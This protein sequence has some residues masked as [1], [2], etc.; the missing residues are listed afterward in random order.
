[1]EAEDAPANAS[2]AAPVPV[3]GDRVLVV[4]QP[5]LDH[6]LEGRKTLEL[7]GRG[8]KP[9]HAWLGMQGR[10]FGRVKIGSS[11][12][13]T[14]EDFRNRE[15]QHL[16]PAGTDPPYA[17]L[18]GLPL[19]DIQR[20]PAPLAYWRPTGAMGWNIYRTKAEDFPLRSR[21]PRG[22]AATA[23][24]NVVRMQEDESTDRQP[25]RRKAGDK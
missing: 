8:C 14:L 15:G 6:I 24:K 9:G 10:I 3:I 11:F 22:Q 18:C 12:T 20:L 1:M 21:A 4:K 16:W 5:W 17:R 19:E 23:P 25:K 2:E 13:M 7:R